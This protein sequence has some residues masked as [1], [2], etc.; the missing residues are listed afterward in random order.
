MTKQHRIQKEHLT[1]CLIFNR[2][3]KQCEAITHKTPYARGMQEA[4]AGN[5]KKADE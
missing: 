5:T 1:I 4:K 2:N 3:K